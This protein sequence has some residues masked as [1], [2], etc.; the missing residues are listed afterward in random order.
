MDSFGWSEA[1]QHDYHGHCAGI[2]ED[3][4]RCECECHEKRK[5]QPT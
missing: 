5:D 1:C 2:T 3:G 4:E